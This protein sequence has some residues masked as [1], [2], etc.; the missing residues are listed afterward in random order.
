VVFRRCKSYLKALRAAEMAAW[1]A[2]STRSPARRLT[3]TPGPKRT[4]SVLMLALAV[5]AT[6]GTVGSIALVNHSFWAGLA[7]FARRALL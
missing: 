5:A 2:P 3:E 7:E 4:D 6:A 1:N